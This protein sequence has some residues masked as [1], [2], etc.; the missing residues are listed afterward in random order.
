MLIYYRGQPELQQASSYSVDVTYHPTNGHPDN[1]SPNSSHLSVHSGDA[2]LVSRTQKQQT[3]QQVSNIVAVLKCV[4]HKLLFY[5]YYL[6]AKICGCQWVMCF[7]WLG[8]ALY[9]RSKQ[10]TYLCACVGDDGDQSGARGTSRWAGRPAR[11]VRGLSAPAGCSRCAE[12]LP[13]RRLRKLRTPDWA[14]TIRHGR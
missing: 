7:V 2:T 1:H 12:C 11:R 14:G 8:N 4:G 6:S 13:S 9:H 3:T 5:Y 10:C